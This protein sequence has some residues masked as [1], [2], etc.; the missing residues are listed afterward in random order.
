M[1]A[2]VNESTDWVSSLVTRKEQF[3]SSHVNFIVEV[4]NTEK[5][6]ALLYKSPG[7]Y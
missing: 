2:K 6:S 1:I 3:Q 5:F 4:K 7:K